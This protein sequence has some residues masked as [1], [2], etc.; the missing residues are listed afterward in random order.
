MSRWEEL[1]MLL[2]ALAISVALATAGGR[3]LQSAWRTYERPRQTKKHR[4]MMGP[5]YVF[6]ACLV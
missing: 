2:L 3:S 1:K 6:R 4:T 5:H